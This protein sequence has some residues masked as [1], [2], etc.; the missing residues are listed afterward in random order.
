MKRRARWHREV[1]V[2][3]EMAAV[4]RQGWLIPQPSRT[5]KQHGDARHLVVFVHGI[6]ASSGVFRPMAFALAQEGLAPRQVHFDYTPVGSIHRHAKRLARVITEARVP[7][8]VVVVAHSLGGLIVRQAVQHLGLHVDALVTMGTPHLGTLVARPWPWRLAQELAPGS[9]A[10]DSLA[11]TSHRL[12]RTSVTSVVAEKDLLVDAESASLPGSRLVS[13]PGVGHHGVLYDPIAW[14]A[15]RHAI[16]GATAAPPR[17]ERDSG[18]FE[19]R[20]SG[21][22][23]GRAG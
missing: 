13:V 21:G 16:R 8:P 14:E 15:V 2:L 5:I 7:G 12:R 6:F 10:I 18:E 9:A 17:E 20:P 1:E 3:R 19:L 11:A 23:T 22:V 4:A